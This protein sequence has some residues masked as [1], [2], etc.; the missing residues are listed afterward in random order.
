MKWAKCT[1]SSRFTY[2]TYLNIP[3]LQ[4]QHHKLLPFTNRSANTQNIDFSLKLKQ[5]NGSTTPPKKRKMMS[6]LVHQS[7]P[8]NRRPRIPEEYKNIDVFVYCC[9]K[10]GS[11]TLHTTMAKNGF[12]SLHCHGN[13][14][15]QTIIHK[16]TDI[17]VFDVINHN[18][19]NKNV[20]YFIDSYLTPIERAMSAFFQNIDTRAPNY[21]TMSIQ[22]L[23][24]RFNVDLFGRSVQN[25]IYEVMDHY[26]VPHFS[27]FDFEKKYNIAQQGNMVFIKVRFSDIKEWSDILSRVFDQSITIS[28]SNLTDQKDVSTLYGEFKRIYRVPRKYLLQHLTKDR[29]FA[30]YN[31]AEEQAAYLDYWTKKSV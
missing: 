17:T 11:S 25:S 8:I 3:M 6:L 14:Y 26:R 19:R 27:S 13:H 15:F 9:G 12:S 29:Q 7:V 10:S 24:A 2:Y 4:K 16:K 28:S 5:T 23:I 20:V 1:K 31:T 30:I 21:K 22:Q 18:R